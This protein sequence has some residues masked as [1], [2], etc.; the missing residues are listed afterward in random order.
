MTHP[1]E[2]ALDI[3]GGWSRNAVRSVRATGI[4]GLVFAGIG[5]AVGVLVAFLV[6]LQFTSGASFVAQGANTSALPTA[7]LGIAASVGLGTARDYSPQFYADLLVSDPVLR[8]AI[9]RRYAV[10]R[11]E[12]VRDYI[13]IEGFEDK[14]PPAAVEAALKHLRRRVA[15]RADVRTNIVSV[16]VTARYPEL[17]RDLTQAL[18]DALDSMNISFRQEQSRELRQFFAG[19]VADA[20]RALDSA[21]TELRHFIERNRVTSNSPLLMLEQ[22]RLTR[23]ADLK[24]AVYTTVV[25]QFEEAK[26]QEARNVP[27]LTVLAQP[28][29][30][31]KKSGPPRRFIAALGV[32]I[33]LAAAMVFVRFRA[34]S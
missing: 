29:I 31:V 24:R 11:S 20:Q 13:E 22:A 6:P 7:L 34:R 33:G 8:S 26:M 15:A 18:L 4:L 28:N 27:I 5:G 10:P 23:A 32:L 9:A 30:P 14:S 1:N 2:T 17:S 19:R 3:V 12:A 21:E 25:Q 16:R